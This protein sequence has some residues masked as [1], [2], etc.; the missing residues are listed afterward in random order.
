MHLP[1]RRDS[2]LFEYECKELKNP[3]LQGFQL[4]PFYKRP[5]LLKTKQ[6]TAVHHS[7]NNV[8]Q[9]TPALISN[10]FWNLPSSAYPTQ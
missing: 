3:L 4:T 5:Q 9:I 6:E 7:S 1:L 2:V 8:E 10:Y